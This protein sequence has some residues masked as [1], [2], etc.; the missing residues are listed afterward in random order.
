M[1][2]INTKFF[3]GLALLILLPFFLIACDKYTDLSVQSPYN[4]AIGKKFAL[5]KDFYIYTFRNSAHTYLGEGFGLPKEIDT[6]YIGTKYIDGD[7]LGIAR[8][9]AIIQLNKIILKKTFESSFD[10]YYVSLVGSNDSRFHA[11]DATGFLNFNKNPPITKT[12][13]DPPIF[14]AKYALPLRSDGV[15]WK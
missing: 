15:W 8:A 10:F 13:S 12:W 7:V 6:K 5:Q 3:A 11:L 2:L 4:Q 1:L 14:D 9:G